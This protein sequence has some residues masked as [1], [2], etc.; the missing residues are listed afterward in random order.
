MDTNDRTRLNDDHEAELAQGL[1]DDRDPR[2]EGDRDANRGVT[3]HAERLVAN[4]EQHEW[5]RVRVTRR[6][7][8]EE[9]TITVPVRREELVMEYLGD[10]K[11][12]KGHAGTVRGSTDTVDSRVV[13]EFVLHEEV[14]R[15]EMDTFERERV[16]VLVDTQRSLVEFSDTLAREEVTVEGDEHLADGRGTARADE[17][18]DRRI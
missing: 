7:V 8:T 17:R 18:G 12:P 5:N 11:A 6:V 15:V 1:R 2:L 14:P 16:Q 13:A 9:R 4:V 3:L 10:E